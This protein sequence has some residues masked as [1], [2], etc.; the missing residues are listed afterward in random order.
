MEI[1]EEISCPS[2]FSEILMS[3]FLLKVKAY[4]LAKMRGCP[5]F[6]LWILI[7]L[8]KM[9]SCASALPHSRE[10]MVDVA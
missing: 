7:A 8:A 3:A 5:G 2:F 9:H 6:S 4:Y 1:C 10:T